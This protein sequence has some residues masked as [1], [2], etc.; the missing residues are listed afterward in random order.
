[1]RPPGHKTICICFWPSGAPGRL[2]LVFGPKPPPNQPFSKANRAGFT[3]L[4]LGLHK[5]MLCSCLGS[6]ARGTGD[7]RTLHKTRPCKR[8]A[9][10]PN[11]SAI[12]LGCNLLVLPSATAGAQG[13]TSQVGYS[14]RSLLLTRI[15]NKPE[16]LKRPLSPTSLELNLW[17]ISMRP[18]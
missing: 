14:F 7:E 12:Q 17:L 2:R 10:P 11:R 6:S 9:L 3:K 18:C 16:P 15:L 8:T 13:E 1:M 4:V 5:C